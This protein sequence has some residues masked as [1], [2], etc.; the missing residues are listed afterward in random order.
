[1]QAFRC[2][3]KA[4]LQTIP[5]NLPATKVHLRFPA[6]SHYGAAKRM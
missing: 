1:M 4:L 3:R 6:L 5:D 2:F